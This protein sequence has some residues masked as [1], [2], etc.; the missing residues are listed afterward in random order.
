MSTNISA[1]Y[2]KELTSYDFLKA[3]AVILM[4]ID[5]AGFYLYDDET[6]MRVIG[7]LCV[8]IWFFLIGYARTAE[9]PR[10]IW[11]GAVLV[12]ASCVISG[13][14]ILPLNILFSIIIARLLREEMARHALYNAETL[15]GMY[16]ILV[17]AYLPTSILFEYGTLGFLFVVMGFMARN[18]EDVTQRIAKRYLILYVAM[19]FA[20][21]WV[22]QGA[23]APE[24]SAAQILFLTAGLFLV[25]LILMRFRSV[26]FPK[27]TGGIG[28]FAAI[29]RILGRWTLEIYVLHII[30]LRAAAAYLFPE[31]FPFME[32]RIIS[33][34][35]LKAIG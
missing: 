31:K 12:S 4:V 21:Y 2:S 5:H 10:I 15:R 24:I 20:A 11:V 16:L 30:V 8:P 19:S 26:T 1:R 23:I 29:V 3:A 22:F 7:R 33:E 6:W 32:L 9:I 17:L 35:V 34:N 28:P 13:I 18:W 14:Y 25:A 27:L